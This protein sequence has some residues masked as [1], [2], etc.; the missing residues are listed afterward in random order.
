MKLATLLYFTI[1]SCRVLASA[2][3]ITTT[4]KVTYR[5]IT[6]VGVKKFATKAYF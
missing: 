4:R 2:F 1:L 3:F 5:D 6:L